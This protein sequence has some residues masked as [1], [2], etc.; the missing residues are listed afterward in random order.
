MNHQ[1][2]RI[3]FMTREPQPVDET[4]DRPNSL[5]STSAVEANVEIHHLAAGFFLVASAAIST[6]F[7]SSCGVDS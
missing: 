3:P 5:P 1:E 4:H 2:S 6:G 7:T